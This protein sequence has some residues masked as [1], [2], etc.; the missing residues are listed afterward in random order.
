VTCD[1]EPMTGHPLKIKQE[2]EHFQTKNRKQNVNF[3]CYYQVYF[4]LGFDAI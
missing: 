1:D 3:P 2:R 4:I